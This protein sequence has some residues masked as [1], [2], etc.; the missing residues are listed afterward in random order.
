M[1]KKYL[2]L[3]LAF[4]AAL[5]MV[6]PLRAYASPGAPS[7]TDPYELIVDTIPGGGPVTLDPASCY[8]TASAELIFNIYETLIFF[9]G[10]RYDVFRA[11]LAEQAWIVSPGATVEGVTITAP[12]YTN[13]SIVFKVRSGIKFQTYCRQGDLTPYPSWS[14]YTLT[15]EDV[16]YSFERWMVHD[17][18]GGPQ[19][20]IYE[21]LLDCYAADTEHA[22]DFG[23]KIDDAVQRQGDYV[24][25]NIA[26][27]GLVAKTPSSTFVI[28]MFNPDGSMR[29]TFW[30]DVAVK[31]LGYPLRILLQ[32]LSQSWASIISKQW[33]I[34]YVIPNGP[35]MN[36]DVP[37]TQVDW[38]G[39]W[40]DY[41]GW[42]DYCG[43]E[44]SPI[45]KIPQGAAHPGVACGTGPYILDR[46]DP[47]TEW[48]VVWNPNYWGGWPAQTPSPPYPPMTSSGI[49]PA[50]YVKRLTVRQ[51]ATE[52]RIAEL[53]SG[54]CDF[55]AI[56]R[57]RAP[58]LHVDNNRNGPTLPG[59]RLNYPIP[60]LQNDAIFFTFD[61]EPRPDN[62]YG[63]INDYNV[64][65]ED[66]IPRNFFSDIHVRKAFIYLINFTMVIYDQLLGE[67]YQPHT[68]A[69]D[70]L[71]YV[72]L[73]QARYGPNPDL[74][75]A[76]QE[77]DQ[78]FGGNLKNVGFTIK[79]T[80]NSGNT[81]REA[82]CENL[83]SLI[84]NNIGNVYYGGKFHAEAMPV[85]WTDYIPDMDLHFLP[86][87]GIG[88][89]A[90]YADIHNF[91]F[92]YMHSEGAF[93]AAQRYSNPT[94]DNLIAQGARAPDGPVRQNIYYQLEAI[95]YDD[96]PSVTLFVP[97]GRGYMRTWVQ[98]HYYNPLYPGIYAYDHWKWEYMRGNVNY[99]NKVS[100]DD[101]VA[102]LDAFGSYAGKMG[103]PVFHTRWNFHCDVDGN[104][105]DT[106]RDRKIDMYDISAALDNFGKTEQ[107]WTPPP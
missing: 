46:Y 13:Y 38:D 100:M 89:L 57:A 107:P 40:G 62:K 90:D 85:A 17:Y 83:A 101:I 98:G 11:R 28:P 103:M 26:N 31:P 2:I 53:Q 80:Y 24:W 59:I 15:A 58:A 87:F 94:V 54:A 81:I 75:K 32:V 60:A 66:G 34:N 65:S 106:W 37:D 88:W 9:D 29:G 63:K 10:E 79:I 36:P 104:P 67:A 84:V 47:T 76:K 39:N 50:G 97:V 30:D 68:F 72:N 105:F 16:E 44:Y 102:I 41:T 45:D 51:R 12:S 70:G 91:A 7:G 8:D 42:V 77:F 49:K 99:D 25:I 6:L 69:V 95:Y 64:L 56:P 19:W 92:P 78:A 48:S 55:A 82:V 1:F 86:C 61:I 74:L 23:K 20:M 71:P 22:A 93:A 4:A 43:W 5:S 96:A 14:E 21:P 33:I 27:P 73:A 3:A 52:V 18:I 35:D